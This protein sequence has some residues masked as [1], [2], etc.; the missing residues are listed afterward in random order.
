MVSSL[1]SDFAPQIAEPFPNG[2]IVKHR[3]AWLGQSFFLAIFPLGN[4]FAI[5]GSKSDSRDEM[6]EINFTA[7][8]I[9]F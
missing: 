2:K 7:K 6:I 3:F 4:G 5:H 8:Q 1:T 9:S